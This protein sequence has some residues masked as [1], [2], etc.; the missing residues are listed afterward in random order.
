L[1]KPA[2][3]AFDVS[4]LDPP[5]VAFSLGDRSPNHAPCHGPR[6]CSQPLRPELGGGA[7]GAGGLDGGGASRHFLKIRAPP[8]LLLERQI[9]QLREALP[10][11]GIPLS[12]KLRQQLV[13][14]AVA[15]KP[16]I[17][18]ALILA[19]TDAALAQVFLYLAPGHAEHWA[20]DSVGGYRM[21]PRKPRQSGSP[22]HPEQHR[23]RLVIAGVAERDPIGLAILY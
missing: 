3:Y 15:R 7:S 4:V 17:L 20:D 14:D 1:I 18:I 13:A 16:Q 11:S 12:S 6:Q 10:D 21:N 5:Q 2:D 8:A 22:Q 19:P 23:F 9:G